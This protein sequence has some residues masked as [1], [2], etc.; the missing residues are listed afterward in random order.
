MPALVQAED[1]EISEPLASQSVRAADKPKVDTISVGNKTISGGLTI[2]R[3][4][5]KAKNLTLT[6][7]VT[8]NR[9]AG[10][11]E[12]KTVSIPPTEKKQ[13]GV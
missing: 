1:L 6:I 7:T 12:E 9:K 4:Q 13:H 3:G 5:R 10:G 8:V 2:G 11:T